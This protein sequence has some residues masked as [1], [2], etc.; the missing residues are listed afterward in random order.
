M[1]ASR[2]DLLR[3]CAASFAAT[4]CRPRARPRRE[5]GRLVVELW[6]AY[7]D[8]VR[9]VLLDLVERF[10]ASQT[11]VVVRAIHQGDYHEAL[12][13]L[14][15]A[16]A[17]GVAPAL[18]HVVL[19][20]IPVSGARRRPRAAR[21][22]RRC[23]RYRVRAS[24]RPARRVR[25]SGA[26]ADG[27]RPVQIVRHRSPSANARILEQEGADAFRHTW[28]E[29]SPQVA[30]RLTT[31]SADG[32][33][34]WGFEVPIS[35]WY[36]V[37][38]VGQAGG[39]LVEPDGRVSLGGDAGVAAVRFWQ[40]LV[41]QDRVMRP[42]AGRRLSTGVAIL[43]REL[44]ARTRGHDVEQYGLRAVPRREREVSC[45]HGA[46]ATGRPR[47]RADGRDDVRRRPRRS[48]RGEAGRLGLRPLDVR[49]RSDHRLVD[50]H[51]V[52]ARHAPR[53]R[54][55]WSRKDGTRDTRTTGSPTISS[56]TWS[57]GRGRPSSLRID[58][59]IVEPRLEV[60]VLTGR[61][62][63]ELMAE[64]REEAARAA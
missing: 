44:L 12:A 33:V 42:P 19:E 64:A 23:A 3:A 10:N 15:T 1:R 16:M 2:R 56:A 34:R 41:R 46:A 35:W 20:V 31:R 37:A 7:G 40:R 49:A 60:A 5:N 21:R 38:M 48:G 30:K 9:R 53:G 43:E 45:R 55:A 8:L 32:E 52:H 63:G 13:K 22:L 62:A 54:P 29:D 6:Y 27:R 17:A 50:A 61:D 25:R 24:A 47:S 57:R 14:R 36:W 39:K 26:R 28:E 58:R 18:T 11:R 59:D 4:G 51:G